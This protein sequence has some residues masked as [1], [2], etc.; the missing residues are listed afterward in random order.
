MSTAGSEREA[1]VRV[2]LCRHG[3]REDYDVDRGADWKGTAAAL[4]ETTGQ[5]VKDPP[6]SRLGHA[7]ARETGD[8][9]KEILSNSLNAGSA[10]KILSSPYLR[11]IQT[12]TPTGTRSVKI[13]SKKACL[14][15]TL[16][17]TIFR[18]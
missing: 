4:A 5:C 10:V 1:A 2:F 17:G 13:S 6:I 14:N 18:P 3:D 7:Q 15:L 16:R 11:C 8:Y 12:A 9:F